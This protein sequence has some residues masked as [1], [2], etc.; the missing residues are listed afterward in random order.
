M[1]YFAAGHFHQG[2]GQGPADQQ[3]ISGRARGQSPAFARRGHRRAHGQVSSGRD[4]GADGKSGLAHGSG[5]RRSLGRREFECGGGGGISRHHRACGIHCGLP[6]GVSF[7]GRAWSEPVLL[8]IAYGF[9]QA[10]KAR[11][12]PQFLPTVRMQ[13][14]KPQRTGTAK[15]AK[16]SAEVL[17]GLC[18]ISLRTLRLGFSFHPGQAIRPGAG[19]DLLFYFPVSRLSHRDLSVSAAG[20]V[21]PSVARPESAP[22]LRRRERYGPPSSA[23]GPPRLRIGALHSHQQPLAIRRRR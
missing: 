20:N 12:P 15:V 22:G 2:R 7:F 11:K 16:A 8:K 3:R 17:C 19:R 9:E 14:L 4:H 10:T 23:P 21:S 13:N 6:V 18:G 1:P 5:Q